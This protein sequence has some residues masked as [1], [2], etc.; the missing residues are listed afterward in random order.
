MLFRQHVPTRYRLG[1]CGTKGNDFLKCSN[2]VTSDLL[3]QTDLLVLHWNHLGES[4][5]LGWLI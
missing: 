2:R 3:F 1:V 4:R 5:L